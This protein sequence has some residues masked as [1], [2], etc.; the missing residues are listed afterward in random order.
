M[1][2]VT[3]EG[4]ASIF[5]PK[6]ATHWEE[7]VDLTNAWQGFYLTHGRAIEALDKNSDEQLVFDFGNLTD[8]QEKSY[9]FENILDYID[10]LEDINIAMATWGQMVRKPQV[11]TPKSD[12][13][14]KPTIQSNVVNEFGSKVKKP[15][16]LLVL[17]SKSGAITFW[18]VSTPLLGL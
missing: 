9:V 13:G 5:S 15:V 4:R 3:L 16:G 18:G 11:E 12:M 17:L 2:V 1:T 14:P 7:I 8:I 6:G 10:A